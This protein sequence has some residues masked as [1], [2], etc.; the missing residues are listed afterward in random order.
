MT[1]V[2][3]CALPIYNNLTVSQSSGAASL[4][5]NIR[6]GGVL[7][8]SSGLLNLGAYYLTISGS[9]AISGSPFSAAKMIVAN[10]GGEVRKNYAANGSYLFPLGDNDSVAEYSPVTINFSSG[11]YGTGAYV[12]ARVMNA[13]H[14][15]NASANHF[16]RRYWTVTTS[17]ITSPNYSVTATYLPSDVSGND[18]SIYMARYSGLLPWTKYAAANTV[19]KILTASGVTTAG[20]SNFTGNYFSPNSV[21]IQG[22][23]VSLCSGDSVQLIANAVG[24]APFSYSWGPA[25][26]RK[27]TRLNSSHEWI[28]R[29]PSSA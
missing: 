26:D 17:A 22:G 13:K 11:T 2:Q 14:P 24:T 5:A 10:G 19:S 4:S 27:S 28:S 9:S 20:S 21:S 29:M 23:G 15:Q 18:S 12:S 1:G 7:N 16:L 3:T 25:I 8:L 6:V